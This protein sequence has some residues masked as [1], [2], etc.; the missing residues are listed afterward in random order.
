[1]QLNLADPADAKLVLTLAFCI[2]GLV[3]IFLGFTAAAVHYL[4]QIRNDVR[5]LVEIR[6]QDARALHT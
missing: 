3:V 1:M 2:S 5:K 4:Q 6:T